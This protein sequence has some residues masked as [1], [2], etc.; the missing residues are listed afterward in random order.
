M[1]S[2]QQTDS[3]YCH[4]TAH[5]MFSVQVSNF[6]L[7]PALRQLTAE[8]LFGSDIRWKRHLQE[9]FWEV[10]LSKGWAPPDYAAESVKAQIEDEV[11]QPDKWLFTGEGLQVSFSAYEGGCY[12]CN[13]GPVEVSWTALKP[14]LASTNIAPQRSP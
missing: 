14:L 6:V 2:V 9:L 10:L 1:I 5:G 3:V 13:P 8:D 11:S 7:R 4:G 12:A